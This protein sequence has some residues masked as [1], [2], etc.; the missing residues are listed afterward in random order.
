MVAEERWSTVN[1]RLTH[2]EA[3]VVTRRLESDEG[4]P[5]AI[6]QSIR[7]LD[8]SVDIYF[9]RTNFT[10]YQAMLEKG[11]C[12]DLSG[13]AELSRQVN[14]M[15]DCIRDAVTVDGKI[16]AVPYG[17]IFG[18]FSTLGCSQA[19]FDTLGI[20]ISELP[21]STDELLDCILSWI[22]AGMLDDLWLHDLHQDSSIL[23][24][25]TL[26]NYI[27]H[28]RQDDGMVDLTSSDFTALM[29]K[30]DRIIQWINTRD[31]PDDDAPALF[32]QKSLGYFLT[33]PEDDDWK[34]L[35]L[36]PYPMMT[37][38]FDVCLN[39][40]VV[41]PLSRHYEEAVSFLECVLQDMEPEAAMLLW[42][43]R[44]QPVENPDYAQE[45][46][47]CHQE[48]LRLQAALETGEGS[49]QQKQALTDALEDAQAAMDLVEASRWRISERTVSSYLAAVPALVVQ[50]DSILNLVYDAGGLAIEQ[51]YGAQQATMEE[52]LLAFAHLSESIAK[53]E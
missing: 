52:L 30:L 12:A 33:S 27:S 19:A 5:A 46:E 45:W 9:T 22:E 51:R 40:A 44:A 31:Q 25:L 4:T 2:P 20:S 8:S 41:N 17:V 32:S 24:G 13:E 26:N 42:P 50:K 47:Y 18:S 21:S 15:A 37:P 10:G 3:S 16:C 6:A 23:Y 48:V 29:M 43:S 35:R 34:M 38:S 11:F 53:E 7:M 28:A 36:T 49:P 1:Y 14:D 39:V